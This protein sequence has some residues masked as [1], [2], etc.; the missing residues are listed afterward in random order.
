MVRRAAL[1][2]FAS[3]VREETSLR[4]FEQHESR[5]PHINSGRDFP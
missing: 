1:I 3:P 4:D 5:R 2:N